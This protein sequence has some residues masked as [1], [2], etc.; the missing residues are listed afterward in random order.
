MLSLCT[1]IEWSHLM[2]SESTVTHSRG[3][4]AEIAC[5]HVCVCVKN[6]CISEQVIKYCRK[7]YF[8]LVCPI[9]SK[10]HVLLCAHSHLTLCAWE[11]PCP[12]LP[13]SLVWFAMSYLPAEVYLFVGSFPEFLFAEVKLC[14]RLAEQ[15]WECTHTAC[16][17]LRQ[18]KRM[19]SPC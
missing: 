19:A 11:G 13:L 15:D 12:R 9:C 5:M 18:D 8:L 1:I 3:G 17:D 14:T 4:G 16:C 2:M 10:P 6:C 7:A